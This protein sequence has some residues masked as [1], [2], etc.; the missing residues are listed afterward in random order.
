MNRAKKLVSNS[1]I[2]TIGN[3]GT[4]LIAFLMVPLYTYTLSRA[5]YG[6]IDIL[7]TTVSLFLPIT[8]LS[9]FDAVFRFSMDSSVNVKEIL[10]SGITV[11]VL[12]AFIEVALYPLLFFFHFEYALA[13]LLILI[14]TS[15]F[16][17]IQNFARA[18]GKSKIFAVAGIVNGLCLAILNI[19]FLVVWNFGITG[20]LYSFF[21]SIIMGIVYL[22]ISLKIWRYIDF[23]LFSLKT[24]KK[25][26]HYSIPLIPN[27]LAWWLT[28]DANRFIILTFIGVSANGL[29]AVANKIPSLLSMM[30]NIFT[31]AWQI[32]AVEEYDSDDVDV[33]YSNTFDVLQSFLFLTVASILIVIRPLLSIIIS[34]EFSSVWQYVPILLISSL[35][36]NLSAF[37]GTV[38]LAVKKTSGLFSTTVVGIV[39]NLVI[40]FIFTP[41][42][43]INGTALGGAVGFFTV[44][45][46]RF[47]YVQ[48]Y[49]NVRLNWIKFLSSFIGIII[50]SSGLY[51]T[52]IL[53]VYILAF[54]F[55]IIFIANIS[56]FG[57]CALFIKS[58]F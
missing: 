29:F 37:L 17:L 39:V 51:V 54:G 18:I 24:T 35:F 49:V 41:I 47:V 9:I 7:M 42:F 36:S 32:S 30:F 44:M 25:M 38:F 56:L 5:D 14:S 21:I 26:L 27:S 10:T 58:Y 40:S 1:I 23:S 46:I 34:P 6:Q 57:K 53:Q 16:T 15:L 22:V 43:G 55:I 8:T 33:F 12:I 48:K 13:F 11:T 4:K 31:Q 28:S 52:N 50:I 45:L 2:F 19:F 20:Y 3:I